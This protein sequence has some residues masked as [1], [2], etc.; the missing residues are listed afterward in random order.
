M[1]WFTERRVF[2]H[3]GYPWSSPDYKGDPTRQFPCPNA[4]EAIA[5]HFNVSI[6]EGWQAQEIQ[7][8]LAIFHKVDHVYQA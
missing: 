8:A 6:H 1:K 7:D 2:G 5:M 3:S 4:M